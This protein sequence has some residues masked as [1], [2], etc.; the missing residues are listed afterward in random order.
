[1]ADFRDSD[2]LT[3]NPYKSPLEVSEAGTD[4]TN[5]PLEIMA[6]WERLRLWYNA[7]LA[8]EVLLVVVPSPSIYLIP[9]FVTFIAEGIL[10]ANVCFCVGH[11]LEYYLGLVGIR[12]TAVRLGIF[13]IGMLL[14]VMLTL[15]SLIQFTRV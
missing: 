7:V 14:A 2:E 4:R 15:F 8:A 13:I 9:G 6:A 1:M 12:G 3:G 10:G 11:V 5:K